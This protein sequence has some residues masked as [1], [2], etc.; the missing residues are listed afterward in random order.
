[1]NWDQIFSEAHLH[2]WPTASLSIQNTN[3]S[4]GQGSRNIF[5]DDKA[6]ILTAAQ[7]HGYRQISHGRVVSFLRS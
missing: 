3:P 2:S 1:M 6:A 5:Q 7:K 4:P